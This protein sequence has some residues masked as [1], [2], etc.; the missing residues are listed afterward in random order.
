MDPWVRIR[1]G[2]RMGRSYGH[3]KFPIMYD[4]GIGSRAAGA[5]AG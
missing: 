2:S 5:L 4:H 1:D 3:C